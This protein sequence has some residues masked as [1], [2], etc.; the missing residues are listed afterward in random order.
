MPYKTKQQRTEARHANLEAYNQRR[1]EQY[2]HNSDRVKKESNDYYY[3]NRE[4]ARAKAKIYRQMR[5]AELERDT[6]LRCTYGITLAEYNQMLE[7]QGGV[8]AI[9]RRT[10]ATGRNLAVDHAHGDNHE[11]RGLLC[12]SCNN[13]LGRFRDNPELLRAA[14]AY[15]ESWKSK[16]A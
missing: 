13:G 4:K 3:R 6:K 14:A 7:A 16:V 15:L 8:C 11:I 5:G 1:R 12:G 2:K 9:C 10:C